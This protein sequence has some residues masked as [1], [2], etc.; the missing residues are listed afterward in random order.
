MTLRL[1][2]FSKLLTIVLLTATHWASAKVYLPKEELSK[3][4]V[5]PVFDGAPVVKDRIVNLKD[6][7]EFGIFSGFNLN[8]PFY[9]PL[10]FGGTISY[11]FTESSALN[12]WGS[13]FMEGQSTY[14]E[15][16]D[17]FFA[18]NLA[19][20]P[21]PEYILTANY[22]FTTHYGKMSVTKDLVMQLSLYFF[23]G[24]GLFSYTGS[25][26]P[27]VNAGLGQKF[28][29]TSKFAIR[30]DL[31]GLLY[32]GPNVL[33]EKV[34]SSLENATERLPADAFNEKIFFET[35]LS[36]GLVFQL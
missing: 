4:S 18:I 7:F 24:G 26:L 22:Q 17:Q 15:D 13:F 20:A 3:E 23:A 32:Q 33:D 19:Q 16:L 21:V 29:L 36:V 12:L 5:L 35:L 6:S 30:F 10:S 31:R 28:Y 11:S 25:T 8:E 14:A 34:P 9:S 1:S 27:V 2:N